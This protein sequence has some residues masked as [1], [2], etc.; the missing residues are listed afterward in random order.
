MIRRPRLKLKD[1]LACPLCHTER[2]VVKTGWMDSLVCPKCEPERL[3]GKLLE[4][5]K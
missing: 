5:Q 2:V 3:K 1:I 4:D